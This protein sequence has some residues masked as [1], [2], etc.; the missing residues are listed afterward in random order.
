MR[1]TD[2]GRRRRIAGAYVAKYGE[3]WRFDVRDGAFRQGQGDAAW[4]FEVVPTAVLGFG[5]GVYSQ[6]RWWFGGG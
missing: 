5:K 6:T 4:V 3:E 1:I 2:E